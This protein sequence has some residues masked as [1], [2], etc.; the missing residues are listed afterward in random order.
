MCHH[1]TLGVFWA[2]VRPGAIR[3]AVERILVLQA[4]SALIARALQD[5]EEVGPIDRA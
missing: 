2:E 3:R 4:H 5:G 1:E